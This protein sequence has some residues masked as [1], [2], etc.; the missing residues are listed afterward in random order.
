MN[1][2]ERIHARGITACMKKAEELVKP[3]HLA[4]IGTPKSRFNKANIDCQT[5]AIDFNTD[6]LPY[7]SSS[8]DVVVCEQVIEHLH[9]VTWFLDALKHILK[10]GGQ[11]LIATENLGSLPNIA[12][13]VLGQAPI[14]TQPVCNQYIGGFKKG[15]L[16]PEHNLPNR[17]DPVF[18]GMTGHVRVLTTKQLLILLRQAGF[19]IDGVYH[20]C[21][22]HFVLVDCHRAKHYNITK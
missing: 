5:T 4:D 3:G 19:V 12:M 14:S 18:A 16:R 22:R 6:I 13:L 7:A 11:L 17:N 8:L 9:N 2:I 21:F 15:L 20:F 1:I 10:P